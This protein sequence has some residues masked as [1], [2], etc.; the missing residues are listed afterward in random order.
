MGQIIDW[1][2]FLSVCFNSFPL[3]FIAYLVLTTTVYWIFRT[4]PDDVC[5]GIRIP[6]QKRNDP[7]CIQLRKQLLDR[8]LMMALAFGVLF[9]IF[10][11]ISEVC[12]TDFPIDNNDGLF[13]SF[14]G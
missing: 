4:A 8:T 11:P 13:S 6:E 14:S 1:Q 3:H 2:S 7:F 5:F 12:P 10:A 9:Y